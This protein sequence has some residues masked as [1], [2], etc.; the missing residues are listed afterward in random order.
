MLVPRCVP[1]PSSY[2]WDAS[3]KLTLAMSANASVQF[4]EPMKGRIRA[5]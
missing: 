3:I 5:F 1:I 4:I 2:V